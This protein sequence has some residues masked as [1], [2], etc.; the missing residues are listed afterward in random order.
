MKHLFSHFHKKAKEYIQKAQLLRDSFQPNEHPEPTPHKV[1]K[2]EPAAVWIDLRSTTIIKITLLIL[3][4]FWVAKR[5]QDL[6]SILIILFVSIVFAAAITP[7]VDWLERHRIPRALGILLI[8]I[9]FFAFVGAI[10]TAMI[11]LIIDQTTE[12]V[13]YLQKVLLDIQKFGIVEGIPFGKKMEPIL[14]KL[15]ENINQAQLL[16]ELRGGVQQ[17]TANLG[18]LAGNV[19][20]TIL[21]LFGGIVQ[22]FAVLFITFFLVL[23][24]ASIEEFGLNLL[25]EKHRE[26]VAEKARK[27]QQKL[28]AWL[29]GQALLS[30]GV[31]LLLYLGLSILGVRYAFTFALIGALFELI[32]IVGPL[33]TGIVCLPIVLT[34]GLAVTTKYIIFILVL[35]WIESNVLNPLIMNKAMALNPAIIVI[36]MLIG[37]EFLGII[38]IVLAVPIAASIKVLVKDYRLARQ[39]SNASS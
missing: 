14:Q 27:V 29:R 16:E 13:S 32:P 12:L 38:G 10:A 39:E 11:P 19:L 35:N 23:D 30:I 6:E 22:A 3:V 34:Q 20:G 2:K 9:L 33:I 37:N 21:S 17:L 24:N 26:V 18:L 7:I 36:A 28:G 5:L 4:V 1:E 15:A 31:G 25:P 8:Y